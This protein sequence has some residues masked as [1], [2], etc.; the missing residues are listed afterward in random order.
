[1]GWQL[2]QNMID[3]LPQHLHELAQLGIA[4]HVDN[5]VV[6]SWCYAL[7]QH[8]LRPATLG[9]HVAFGLEYP[10][11]VAEEVKAVLQAVWNVHVAATPP[12]FGVCP[13]VDMVVHDDEIPNKVEFC[14]HL[15]V[16]FISVRFIDPAVRK[17]LHQSNNTPLDK[18]D[19]G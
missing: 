12:E 13:F 17:D 1:M 8:H 11:G 2:L 18:M 15:L 4:H 14:A 16:E 7:A 9:K 5:R 10:A 6:S 3:A 19:T